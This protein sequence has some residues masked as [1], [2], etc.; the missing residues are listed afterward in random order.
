MGGEVSPIV[1]RDFPEL[2]VLTSSGIPI[3]NVCMFPCMMTS[4]MECMGSF[5]HGTSVNDHG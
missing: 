1:V 2:Q 4:W 3:A 5:A